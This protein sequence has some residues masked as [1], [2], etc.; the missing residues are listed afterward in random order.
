MSLDRLIGRALRTRSMPGE[1]DQLNPVPVG[2]LD[3]SNVGVAVLHRA[4]LADNFSALAAQLI[5]GFANAL[6][7]DSQV[8]EGIADIILVRV[9]IISQLDNGV[10]G[11]IER[12]GETTRG[13]AFFLRSFILK[14]S[15]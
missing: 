12:Q 8:A 4:G 2:I 3:K 10:L 1:I 14:I 6:D 9:P 5:A 11:F 7:S 13:I 15:Q